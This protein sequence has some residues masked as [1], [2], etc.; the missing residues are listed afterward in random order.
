MSSKIFG[1]ELSGLDGQL[2]EIEVDTRMSLPGFTI[3]GLPDSAVLEAKERVISAV[4]N[5]N[6]ALPRGKIVVNLAPADMR[7]AGPRY[8]LP[9]ALGLVGFTERLD[10]RYFEDTVFLG[11]LSLDAKIRPVTGILASVES[12]KQMGFKRVFVPSANAHEAAIIEGIEIIP[13]GHLK[14]A[15]LHLNDGLCALPIKPKVIQVPDCVNIDLSMIKGQSHAKRALEVAAAGG[16]NLLLNGVPGAGKTLMARA[17]RGI[18]PDMTQEEMLEV[19][20]IYSVAGK[21]P[22]SASLFADRPFR[23]VHHTASAVSIVGGGS[24]PM[25]GEIT[26]AHRG[27]LFMDEIA[28][29]PG[30]VLEVLRQP[31][32]DR[33]ITVSRARATVTYP[34][35]FTLVA[36]M[37]PCPC[38]YY[39]VPEYKGR[40]ECPQ[41][42]VR[43]YQKKLS[44]PLLDRIDIHLTIKAVEHETLMQKGGDG[45][46]S[47]KVRQRV[48]QAFQ[49][50]IKRLASFGLT[51]NAEMDG[52]L[53]E[54]FCPLN[55]ASKDLL[56]RALESLKLSARSYFKI[57]KLARTIADLEASDNITEDH[58]VEALTYMRQNKN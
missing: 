12:V 17:L 31:M 50:Q 9:I 46:T 56:R 38:G 21:L 53:I 27:V 8:D 25:P 18:L 4:K 15:I 30:T 2:V 29:F 3:V 47:E 57:I 48:N 33:A 42:M 6:I 43:N 16:H 28:E 39:N 49:K 36:A 58:I 34:A 44:G 23:A 26:L 45:E 10:H 1:I 52:R 51:R 35:Q 5:C 19:T 32:E 7:K 41:W 37:N 24:T 13:V 20:R 40:C 55:K 22:R 54:Q 14:E 11:E